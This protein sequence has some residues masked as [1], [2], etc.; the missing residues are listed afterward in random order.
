MANVTVGVYL[1]SPVD[2]RNAELRKVFSERENHPDG[3]GTILSY[4]QQES[5]FTVGSSDLTVFNQKLWEFK[6]VLEDIVYKTASPVVGHKDHVVQQ[7]NDFL[8]PFPDKT[9]LGAFIAGLQRGSYYSTLVD[10]CIELR[11][12]TL[13]LY[14][15]KVVMYGKCPVE[16]WLWIWEVNREEMIRRADELVVKT[17]LKERIEDWTRDITSDG[18]H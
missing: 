16:N 17:R 7:V 4:C 13:R 6:G 10:F 8:E 1:G 18:Y 9:K 3:L 15:F 11:G 14:I 2:D 5:G 12:E